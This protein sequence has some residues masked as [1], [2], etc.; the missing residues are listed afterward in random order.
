MRDILINH[1]YAKEFGTLKPGVPYLVT[2]GVRPTPKI[3]DLVWKLPAGELSYADQKALVDAMPAHT[4]DLQV[5]STYRVELG[6]S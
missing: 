3:P 2:H 4:E 6:F 5:G 1:E